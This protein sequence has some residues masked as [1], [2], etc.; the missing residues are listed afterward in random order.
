MDTLYKRYNDPTAFLNTLLILDNWREALENLIKKDAED[1]L[2][3]MYLHS[4]PDC[5]FGEWKD[6]VFKEN[7]QKNKKPL[8]QEEV[9]TLVNN[10]EDILKAFKLQQNGG[11][12]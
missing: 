8:N 5:S 11:E 4:Y 7:E 6:K 10:A 1:R 2:F 9:T 12:K 3:Q